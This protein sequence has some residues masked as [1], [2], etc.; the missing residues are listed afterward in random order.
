MAKHWIKASSVNVV[1]RLGG[2]T[3]NILRWHCQVVKSSIENKEKYKE[4]AAICCINKNIII[5]TDHRMLVWFKTT[6]QKGLQHYLLK[7]RRIDVVRL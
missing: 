7:F 6:V 5:G 2:D 1:E 3:N 4:K